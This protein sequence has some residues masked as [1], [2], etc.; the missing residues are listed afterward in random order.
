VADFNSNVIS[1]CAPL[2]VTFRDQSTGNPISWNW[3]FGGGNL[4]NLQNPVMTFSTPGVYSVTLVVRNGNGTNGITKTNY[5]T[6][7]PSPTIAFIASH[8]TGCIPT[9]IQFTDNTTPGTG[10]IASWNWD[11]GDGN[12][13]TQQNPSN[14]YTTAGF[15]TVALRAVN[16][17]GCESQVAYVRHIRLP[18]A[19]PLPSTLPTSPVAQVL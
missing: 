3:D 6:V 7:N 4:S 2:N 13:S 5:I 16:S 14:Q 17:A 1:G 10:G 11:F 19:P 8:T 9:T 18:A 12:T 15:Y